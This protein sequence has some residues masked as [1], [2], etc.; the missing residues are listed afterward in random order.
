M[1]G[2]LKLESEVGKGSTFYFTVPFSINNSLEKN[3][4]D[5]NVDVSEKDNYIILNTCT[6][7]LGNKQLVVGARLVRDN[8][9]I[10]LNNVKKSKEYKTIENVLKGGDSDEA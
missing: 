4:F 5:I 1:G 8:E 9:K 10:A 3:I 6:R 2:E 7:L